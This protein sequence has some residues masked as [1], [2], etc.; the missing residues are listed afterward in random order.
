MQSFDV[1]ATADEHFPGHVRGDF[2]NISH[3][4][5]FCVMILYIAV[6]YIY[7]YIYITY[8]LWLQPSMGQPVA[9]PM[10]G[11]GMGSSMGQPAAQPMMGF[12]MGAARVIF[13]KCVYGEEGL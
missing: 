9:Q 4:N 1:P 11:F 7:I 13:S 8:V 3:K 12:G 6:I 5:R 10:M 2:I